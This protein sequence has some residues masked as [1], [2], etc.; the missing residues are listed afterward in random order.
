M[1]KKDTRFSSTNQPKGRGKSTKTLILDMLREE[2]LLELDSKS[3]KQDAEKAFFKHVALR[4][5]NFEDPNSGMCLNL[6][7]NKGW[8]NVKPSNET[9]SFDF[10]QAAEPH[11]QAGQ[12][13][14]AAS[15]G[16][17]PPDIANTFIQSIKA[18]VDIEEYVDLKARIEK[19]ESALNGE[20]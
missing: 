12:V 20:S 7:A 3:S 18:M 13:M 8:A 5:T 10:D 15:S 14:L 1:T 4:A 19:L 2:S 11:I 17:I 9:V 6:L 16:I